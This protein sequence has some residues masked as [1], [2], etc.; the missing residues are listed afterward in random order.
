MYFVLEVVFTCTY[1]VLSTI[2]REK[3]DKISLLQ[4]ILLTQVIYAI[5]QLQTKCPSFRDFAFTCRTSDTFLK[6][7]QNLKKNKRGQNY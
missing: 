7:A 2:N 3:G 1:Y 6:N 5:N 4:F